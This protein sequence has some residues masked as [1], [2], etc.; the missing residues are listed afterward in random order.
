MQPEEETADP[1]VIRIPSG[2]NVESSGVAGQEY[3]P[4][5]QPVAISVLDGNV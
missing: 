5:P 1:V 3:S 2:I 4:F